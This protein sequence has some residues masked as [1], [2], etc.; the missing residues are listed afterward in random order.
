M[1]SKLDIWNLALVFLRKKMI[2]DPDSSSP[3]ATTMRT[4]YPLALDFIIREHPWSFCSKVESLALSDETS[5]LYTYVYQ[6]P[7]DCI[8]ATQ[9]VSPDY[10]HKDQD[11][12][13]A[14]SSSGLK[15]ILTD[16][17]NAVLRYSTRVVKI[18]DF[19]PSFVVALASRLAADA[20]INL[21]GRTDIWEAC[22]KRY[23]ELI[24]K[25]KVADAK[26][27]KTTVKETSSIAESR[28]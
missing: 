28:L 23:L 12:E 26:E 1:A 16:V 15:V 7:L 24:N 5:P 6:Y 22:E 25:A 19:D 2:N 13:I 21:T 4:V 18:N 9:L 8:K 20:A 14:T 10:I 11:Y 27:C 3:E 17:S